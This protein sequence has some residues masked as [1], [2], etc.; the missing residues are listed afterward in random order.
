MEIHGR[1]E[2]AAFPIGRSMLLGAG[3]AIALALAVAGSVYLSMINHGHSFARLFAWQLGSWGFWALVA[4]LVLRLGSGHLIT[5]RSFASRLVILVVVGLVLI[6]MHDA[7]T[8]AFTVWTRPFFPLR[9]GTFVGN[10]SAQLPS[11]VVIDAFL[12]TVLVMGGGAYHQHRRARELDLRESRLEAELARAQLH[13]LQLEIQP[14]FLF[15]TLNSISALIRLKDHDGALKML[16]GL[17]DLLRT[18]VERPKDQLVTL[19]AEIEFVKRYVDLQ[20]TRFADRLQVDYQIGDD[21]HDVTVPTFLLQ[22]LVENALRHG[23]APRAS[24]C[25]VHIGASA[26]A[27]RLRIWVSD[28][29]VGLPSGFDLERDA[30]TG[31]SNT[32]S[33]LAQLYGAAATF[34]VRAGTAAGTIVEI[35][36]PFSP[37][38]HV[39]AIAMS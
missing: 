19:S 22:P 1:Q 21:C 17:S 2:T 33:R 13:A 34:E 25:H 8:A 26:D 20:R 15:N 10:L 3:V 27:G 39:A 18:A 35:A 6:A 36:F 11:I 23:A 32:R 30:G 38:R 37:S 31:L 24:A 9:A 14:H 5:S 29:G 16:L 4:P 12:Y 28:D 7:V